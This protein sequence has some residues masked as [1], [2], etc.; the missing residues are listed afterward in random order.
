MIHCRHADNFAVLNQSG[1]KSHAE[2]HKSH[3]DLHC[4]Y[5]LRSVPNTKVGAA[6]EHDKYY[7]EVRPPLSSIFSVISI[8]VQ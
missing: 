1:L 4:E 6:K 5:E 3:K 7:R 2:S 8:A